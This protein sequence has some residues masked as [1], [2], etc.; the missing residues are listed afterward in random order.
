MRKYQSV[1]KVEVLPPDEH[2]RIEREL[3]RLGKTSARELD[4]DERRILVKPE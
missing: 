4:S 3:H 2:D 1:E